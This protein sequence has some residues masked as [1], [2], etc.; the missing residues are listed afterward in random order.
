MNSYSVNEAN[1]NTEY[2]TSQVL[3]SN[4]YFVNSDNDSTSDSSVTPETLLKGSEAISAKS[5][6]DLNIGFLTP[7]KKT[8]E[9]AETNSSEKNLD[10]ITQYEKINVESFKE[11]ILQNLRNNIKE[12]FNSEFTIFKSKCE[13]LVQTSSVRYNKQID[14][15][16]NQ[17]KTKDKIIDQLLKSLSSLT[18]SELESKNNI[19]HK[20]LDQ[21]NDEEKKKLIRPQNGITTKSDIADNNSNGKHSTKKTKEH[22]ERNKANNSPNNTESRDVKP[23]TN[24]RKKIRVE[25]WVILMLNG[26][27]E[28]GLN[29]NADINIKIRKYPGA[30]STDILGHIRPSLRKEPDQIIIH[31][32]IKDLTNDHN[33][34]NNVKKIVEIVRETCKNTELSFSSLICRNDLKDIDEKVKKTNAH[35]ENYCKQQNLVFID[36]SNLNKSDLNSRGLHL[37]ERGS[38]KLARNFLDYFY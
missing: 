37:Q 16:Q 26:V 34:L 20:L 21:T 31:A 22:A 29:K 24:K 9:K 8:A 1:T 25:Y 36:N 7:T 2:G 28:K 5:I 27:Q 33:Y 32:G 6:P 38:S 30:S 11:S 14:H 12:I 17:L 4:L 3:S 35:L 19:I 15:L 10:T 13:E 18:N 23:K